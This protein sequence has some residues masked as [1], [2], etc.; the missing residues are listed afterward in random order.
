MGGRIRIMGDYGMT[1]TPQV[2]LERGGRPQ[3]LTY[4]CTE[5]QPPMRSILALIICLATGSAGVA[6]PGD[7][8]KA[9]Q[10]LERVVVALHRDQ[11][12]ALQMFSAGTDGFKDGNIYPFCFRIAD[13]IVLT[14]QTAGKDIRTFPGSGHQIY[15]AAQKPEGEV[16]EIAYMARRP[17]PADATPVKKVSVVRK[18][19]QLGCGVGYYP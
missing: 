8:E 2:P 6:D 15:E 10:M 19:G 17:P 3:Y 7:A 16:T 14:G 4:D 9:K 11:T 5:G 1:S 18:I 12:A 13:G